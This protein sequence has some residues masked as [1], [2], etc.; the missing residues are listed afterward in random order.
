MIITINACGD[1]ILVDY[2]KQERE[3]G[4]DADE[5]LQ[6]PLKRKRSLV[7]K[8]SEPPLKQQQTLNVSEFQ[9]ESAPKPLL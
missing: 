1:C 8:A 6:K 9:S 4:A 7:G 2:R 3:H 5:V